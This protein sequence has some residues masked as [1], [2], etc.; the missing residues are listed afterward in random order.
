MKLSSSEIK[1][2]VKYLYQ[3]M[4]TYLAHALR[5]QY[6]YTQTQCKEGARYV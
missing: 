4:L 3:I 6:E 2:R 5:V 1:I